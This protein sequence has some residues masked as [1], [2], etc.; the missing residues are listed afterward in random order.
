MLDS[1]QESTAGVTSK[2]QSPVELET[3]DVSN[4]GII[5]PSY[6]FSYTLFGFIFESF[7]HCIGY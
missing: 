7:K 5:F 2:M 4:V 1:D 6:R 3:A